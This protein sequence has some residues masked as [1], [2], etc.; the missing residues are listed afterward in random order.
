MTSFDTSLVRNIALLGHAG[1]GKTTLAECMLY[2]AGIIDRQGSV[3]EGNTVGDHHPL[4]RERGHTFFSKLMHADWKGYKINIID[5]P[6]FDDFNG[7]VISALRVA[8]TGI[9][10]INACAGVE[11]G[12]DLIWDYTERFK[13]P[14][15]LAINKMDQPEADFDRTLMEAR[16][17]FGNKVVPV[18]FPLNP[19]NGFNAVVDLLR[20]TVYEYPVGGGMPEK[21]PIPDT[22]REKAEQWHRELVEAVAVNDETLME[23]YL[24]RGELD[25]DEMREGLKRSLASHDIFPVFCLSAGEDMGAG[26]LMSFIDNVCPSAREMAPQQTRSGEDLPCDASGPACLF[27]FKTIAEPHVGEL[28][29]FKVYSGTIRTGMELVNES[30]GVTEKIS[31]LFVL[32]GNRRIQV[33][34]LAAGDIGATLKLRN[35]HVNNTLHIKGRSLELAPIE[36]PIPNFT[37]AIEPNSKGEEDKL[38]QALHTLVQEDPTLK[39]E[40]SAELKQTL[41]Y[42]QGEMHLSVIKW[43]L[44]HV[45][46]VDVR[47]RKQ[48]I[49]YRETL[50]S[51]ATSIWRHKKQSGGAGQF[52]E[53]HMRV[54][55]WREG[56]GDPEGLNVRGREEHPLEWGGRLVFLN[57]IVGGAIDARF[58]PSILK[59]VMERMQEGPLTGSF[60]RDVRVS[61]YDGK[62]H[63]VDSNDISFKVAGKM[64]FREAFKE[65]DPQLLEPVW[66]LEVLC[67]DELTGHVMGDLQTRRAMVEG[68]DTEGHFQRITAR[69]PLAETEGYPSVLRS[70]TQGRARLRM[71]FSGYA[72][73][74]YETQHRLMEDY[75]RQT[76]PM[77]A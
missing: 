6:G 71:T 35:T 26:R 63:P 36:F 45:H 33:E 67:P 34:E 77:E 65:A 56:M 16:V 13:T 44:E 22:E 39:V 58:L 47:L 8:D 37:V 31:Q 43:K 76:E 62:M 68:I 27:V 60:V 52:A 51:S 14:M 54:E 17:H 46:H 7:E 23:H 9:M 12:A 73:V 61:V 32:E 4:E 25:E 72:P 29:L 48:G 1:T 5:T 55:A 24:D 40:V 30:N 38:S 59:G 69:V 2:E 18:Q 10:L 42:C 20:M 74:P 11:V 64:A 66:T 3:C 28:S 41:L 53:V 57:C 70:L 49:P 19:G 15:I 75:H 21:K 50:R